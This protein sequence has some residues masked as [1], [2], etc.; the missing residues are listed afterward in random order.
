[1][2]SIIWYQLPM[3]SEFKHTNIHLGYGNL[4]EPLPFHTVRNVALIVLVYET[5]MRK[6]L[7]HTFSATLQ[8]TGARQVCPRRSSTSVFGSR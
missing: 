8:A 4:H 3:Y 1:M 6:L 2:N 5:E 7:D